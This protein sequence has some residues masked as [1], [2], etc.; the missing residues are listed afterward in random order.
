MYE[1]LYKYM[2]EKDVDITCVGFSYAYIN[3]NLYHNSPENFCIVKIQ[4][5]CM[6]FFKSILWGNDV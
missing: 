4:S 3:K 5:L 6:K 1:S 2:R